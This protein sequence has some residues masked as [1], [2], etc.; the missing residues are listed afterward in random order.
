M[1]YTVDD[2]QRLFKLLGQAVWY[3]Q[4]LELVITQ[5][6]YL[7]TLKQGQGDGKRI[8]EDDVKKML[9]TKKTQTLEPL[10]VSAKE[11]GALPDRLEDRFKFFLK[12]RSWILH[13]CVNDN[14]LSFKDPKSQKIFFGVLEE[15]IKE[16]KALKAE[17]FKEMESWLEA[18]GYDLGRVYPLSGGL[19][20]DAE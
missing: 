1:P 13:N 15:Y 3:T 9:S 4:H 19:L 12:T 16:A 10:I 14:H 5:N 8:R 2:V 18:N 6:K 7:M 17:I 20:K 11:Q